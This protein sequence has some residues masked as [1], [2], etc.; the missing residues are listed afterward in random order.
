MKK[1]C[2][3]CYKIKALSEFY[4]DSYSK[5]FMS[6]CKSCSNTRSREYYGEHRGSIRRYM[7]RYTQDHQEERKEYDRKYYLAN[8][9]KKKARD[10][11]YRVT[12]REEFKEYQK[13]HYNEKR[14]A[15]LANQERYRYK[16]YGTDPLFRIT[17]LLRSRLWGALKGISKARST[18]SL[19]GCSVQY[20]KEHLEK[21]FKSRMTW[22]NYGAW[23]IDHRKPCASFDLSKPS[24]QLKCFNYRNL[25]PLWAEEN[26]KKSA[27]YKRRVKSDT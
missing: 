8:L 5:R 12:H 22:K 20:L 17:H 23:H 4:W 13:K 16:K 1:K 18:L 14:E 11:E 9:S 6:R 10:K 21:Q 26:R 3:K 15:H 19:L 7:T 24:E 2:T 25:Q 27:K